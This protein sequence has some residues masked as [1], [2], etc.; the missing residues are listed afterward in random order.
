MQQASQPLTNLQSRQRAL[1][2][3]ITRFDALATRVTALQSA[4]EALG[5]PQA[6]STLAG[7]SSDESAVAVAVGS[8]AVAGHYD[9]VVNDLAR[10]QVTASTSTA[11]DANTTVVASAGTITI[12]GLAVAVAGD[13]TLRGLAAA[14]NDTD[15]IGV[16]AAVVKTG[17]ASYRLV[18]TSQETGSA[19]AFTVVNGLTG[20][21]TFGAN[22]VDA[23]DASILIN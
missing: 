5:T 6:V 2:T 8:D 4:A 16:H 11:P 1:E 10:A 20:S 19:H 14:I 3:Q 18:L 17:D 15:G 9:V 7:R 22:A 13:V 12:G 21:M 23:S